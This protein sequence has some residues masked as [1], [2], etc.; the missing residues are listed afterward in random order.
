MAGHFL[1]S[2]ASRDLSVE[3]IEK[4]TDKAVHAYFAKMR[5]GDDGTQVCPEC[6]SIEKH[7]WIASR[8]QWRCRS[9]ACGRVFSVTSGTVFSD[10]KLPLKKILKA[11]VIFI[12][13]VKGISA[14]ALTRELGVAYQTAFVLLHKLREALT[15]KLDRT[16]LEGVIHMDGAHISGRV[17]KPR[18]KKSTTKT[19]ARDRIPKEAFPR[20]HNR[21]IAMVARALFAEKGKGAQ[22][23]IAFIAMSEDQPTIMAIAQ[24][25]IKPG[26][27]V[28]T[29]ELGGYTKLAKILRHRTV[30]HS[31]E[32]ST[33]EGVSNNQAESF[34][35]R[36]RRFI[37]G[38]VH[39]VTPHYMFDYMN[40]MVWREDTRR[41]RPTEKLDWL[42][43]S[44]M[45]P[46]SEK[47]RY[48][49]RGQDRPVKV[50]PDGFL[51]NAE[52][53]LLT[54]AELKKL[55][56]SLREPSDVAPATPPGTDGKSGQD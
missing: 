3:K 22:R 46:W 39:R 37:I 35:A 33:D 28:M 20:H 41:D 31:K 13:N 4:M 23:S 5:W 54:P 40:E 36:V 47:W 42:V 50:K 9:V 34:F 15:K 11:M 16:P 24:Q 51:M 25:Y 7:Y 14:L 38:Q 56:E 30:N 12:N 49:W 55:M 21:R 44:T 1:L 48:Y 26:S 45:G 18:V 27:E 29:D 32:F 19:Q 17:R 2:P 10:H 53:L 8:K 52:E 43:K 6:G